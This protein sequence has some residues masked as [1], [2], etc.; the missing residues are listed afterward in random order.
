MERNSNSLDG[1]C[2]AIAYAMGIEVNRNFEQPY[3]ALSIKEFW[4]RWHISLS[5]WLRDYVYIPLGGNR[6]KKT[7]WIF[8][9]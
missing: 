3:F 6:V 8:V 7:K 4:Q 5:S 9:N 2:A 1:I